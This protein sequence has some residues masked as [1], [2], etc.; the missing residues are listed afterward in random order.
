[1]VCSLSARRPSRRFLG[2]RR[3]GIDL[4]KALGAS[5]ETSTQVLSLYI[6][7]QDRDGNELSDQRQWVLSAATI[8]AQV[9]G[10]VTILPPVE[11]GWV[12]AAGEIIW[13]RPVIVYS[14]IRPE[15]LLGALPEL[16]AFLHDM[17]RSTSQGE[18][19]VEFDG[20]FYRITAFDPPGGVP[21]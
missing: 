13:E 11:G 10:G 6:P 12:N 21:P 4:G 8:L 2:S 15:R 1:M 16:R 20:R 5:S 19:V 7:S 14:Y 18:V 3:V 17:G 9:G